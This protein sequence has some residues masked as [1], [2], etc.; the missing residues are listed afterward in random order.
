MATPR[1]Q[2]TK[3][4]AGRKGGQTTMN[5]HSRK[6]YQEAGRKGGKA[7]LETHGNEHMR[8]IGK[9]GFAATC[10]RHYCG[11]R[12]AMLNELIRRGLRSM[13]PCPW[14]G[15]W[16]NFTAFPDPPQESEEPDE[17]PAVA[18]VLASIRSA[19]TPPWGGL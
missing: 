14:N 12:R 16:Q 7:T 1:R 8:R 13:D 3:A 9:A 17:N 11:D 6:H 2:L 19:P 18:F 10:N 5:R 15:A 4:E